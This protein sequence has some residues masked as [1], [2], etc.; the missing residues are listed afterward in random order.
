MVMMQQKGAEDIHPETDKGYHDG[1]T[2]LNDRRV[3]EPASG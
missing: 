3:Y 1:L 2:V